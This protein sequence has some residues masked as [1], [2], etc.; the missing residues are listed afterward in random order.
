MATEIWPKIGWRHQAI[1]WTNVD[2]SIT[3]I[4]LKIAFLTKSI[5]ISQGPMS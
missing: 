5:Q 4:N 3:N 1:T 2:L